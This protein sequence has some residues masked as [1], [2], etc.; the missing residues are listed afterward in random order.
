MVSTRER[1]LSGRALVIG[2]AVVMLAFLVVALTMGPGLRQDVLQETHPRTLREP[3]AT[4]EAARGTWE[5]VV[6]YDGTANCVEVRYLE[7]VFDRACDTA[8][9]E[10]PLLDAGSATLPGSKPI[11]YGVA[12]EDVAEVRLATSG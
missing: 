10:G 8:G 1:T 9:G 3:I 7:Q 2:G 4:G 5:A 6:R 11:V 12:A